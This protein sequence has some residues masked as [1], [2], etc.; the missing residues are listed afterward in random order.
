LALGLLGKQFFF[1]PHDILFFS[2][3]HHPD[4]RLVWAKQNTK[5][6]ICV[7]GAVH[8][9]ILVVFEMAPPL[10]PT[11]ARADWSFS[12]LSAALGESSTLTA[13]TSSMGR[14]A[15]CPEFDGSF[16]GLQKEQPFCTIFGFGCMFLPSLF[17]K[18]TQASHHSTHSRA[19]SFDSSCGGGGDEEQVREVKPDQHAVMCQ[20]CSNADCSSLPRVLEAVTK[21]VQQASPLSMF[22]GGSDHAQLVSRYL[23]SHGTE[24]TKWLLSDILEGVLDCAGRIDSEGLFPSGQMKD[25]GLK[26]LYLSDQV[27]PFALRIVRRFQKSTSFLPPTLSTICQHC[28]KEFMHTYPDFSQ[29]E[30]LVLTVGRLCVF[31]FIIPAI[32][33]PKHLGARCI[34]KLGKQMLTL[35]ARLV[36]VVGLDNTSGEEINPPSLK[37]SLIQ[38]E[39]IATVA[40][41]TSLTRDGDDPSVFIEAPNISIKRTRNSPQRR[42]LRVSMYTTT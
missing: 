40:F 25:H 13:P 28:L 35:V 3:V 16:F 7:A 22:R 29:R 31:K 23:H 11:A 26:R 36:L 41:L 19:P 18:K 10:P 1:L 37:A 27:L 9:L 12:S 15:S 4:L 42:H 34:S 33:K 17:C 30:A 2:S 5:S 20:G 24:Y 8:N 14:H 21:E 6:W 32:I 38:R 39:T